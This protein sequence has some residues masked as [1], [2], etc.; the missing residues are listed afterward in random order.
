MDD[1]WRN[2]GFEK[3]L[4]ISGLPVKIKYFSKTAF[5]EFLVLECDHN[6]FYVWK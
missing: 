1:F 3:T 6:N 5:W 2:S 4:M